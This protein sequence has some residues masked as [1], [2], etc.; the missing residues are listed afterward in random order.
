MWT[1]KH[2]KSLLCENYAVKREIPTMQSIRFLKLCRIT[3]GNETEENFQKQQ[4]II[5]LI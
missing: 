5:N 1:E 3:D 4:S 2:E